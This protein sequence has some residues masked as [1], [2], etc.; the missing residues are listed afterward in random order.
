M[1]IIINTKIA[2]FDEFNN[3]LSNSDYFTKCVSK[4]SNIN[5]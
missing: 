2:E 5:N 1:E 4:I 3:K